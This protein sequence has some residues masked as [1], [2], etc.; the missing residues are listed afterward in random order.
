[1]KEFQRFNSAEEVSKKFG[2]SKRLVKKFIEHNFFYQF[3]DIGINI[4]NSVSKVIQFIKNNP[5]YEEIVFDL[6]NSYFDELREDDSRLELF[7]FDYFLYHNF[8]DKFC[9]LVKLNYAD[10]KIIKSKKYRLDVLFQE[11]IT[12]NKY[13]PCKIKNDKSPDADIDKI[14]F[15]LKKGWY[16]ELVRNTPFSDNF[17]NIGTNIKGEVR[18]S[19]SFAWNIIQ[20]YYACYEYINSLVFT[21]QSK[22]NTS[23]HK[24]TLNI[25]ANSLIKKLE[26]KT[27]FYPFCL[28]SGSSI[29]R[30]FPNHCKYEYARY[31]RNHYQTIEDL[32]E[33]VIKSLKNL[34]R[35]ENS[36]KTFIDFLY[37]FRVWANYTGIET[38]TKLQDGF[39]LDFLKRNLGLLVFFIGGITEIAVLQIAGEE[40]IIH[41]LKD[42]DQNYISKHKEYDNKLLNPIFIRFRIYQHLGIISKKAN[43]NFLMPKTIDPIIF[44]DSSI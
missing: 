22:I 29:K 15:H 6:G 41:T 44:I 18:Y 17:L 32:N 16:N 33:E 1:M 4:D 11:F 31:P 30:K 43:L 3:K 12:K 2:I 37:Q 20:S 35:K 5:I 8:L 39:Y 14:I 9:W 7:L 24:K 13:N 28:Y 27:L 34:Y 36:P 25:F 10:K 23:Q 38:I 26:Q 40:K 19:G 21:E 42:L